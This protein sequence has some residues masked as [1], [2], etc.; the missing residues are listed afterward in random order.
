MAVDMSLPHDRIRAI[1]GFQQVGPREGRQIA[2]P[3]GFTMAPN[4]LLVSSPRGVSA[5][6]GTRPRVMAEDMMAV[7]HKMHDTTI[8]SSKALSKHLSTIAHSIHL[9]ERHTHE[10]EKYARWERSRNTSFFERTMQRMGLGQGGIIRG[11][12]GMGGSAIGGGASMVGRLAMGGGAAMLRGLAGLLGVGAPAVG[13]LARSGLSGVMQ[14]GGTAMTGLRRLFSRGLPAMP[15]GGAST[16]SMLG[17]LLPSGAAGLGSRLAGWGGTA[18]KMGGRMLGWPLA[19]LSAVGIGGY[20][21]YQGYNNA[22]SMLGRKLGPKEVQG[23]VAASLGGALS[24]LGT[25][26]IAKLFGH[27]NTARAIDAAITKSR[28]WLSGFTDHVGDMAKKAFAGT[29][30]AAETAVRAF[31][32]GEALN[33]LK[34]AIAGG[35]ESLTQ[36]IKGFALS[37]FESAKDMLGKLFDP[38]PVDGGASRGGYE[39]RPGDTFAKPV[40]PP[41]A[42]ASGGV[43]SGMGLG[44]GAI[45]EAVRRSSA[46]MAK[47]VSGETIGQPTQLEEAM[48]RGFHSAVAGIGGAGGTAAGALAG[49][50]AP[51]LDAAANGLSGAVAGPPSRDPV[52]KAREKAK[53]SYLDKMK[54]FLEKKMRD[55]GPMGAWLQSQGAAALFKPTPFSSGMPNGWMGEGGSGG[56]GGGGGGYRGSRGGGG[57]GGGGGDGDGDGPR[58]SAT[59][60][61]E[62][63]VS[64]EGVGELPG[65]GAPPIDDNV[66]RFIG[67][68]GARETGFRD[69]EAA[70][71]ANNQPGNNSNVRRAMANGMSQEDAMAKYGDYGYFQT[72]QNDVE[73]AI[74]LG[75]PRDVAQAL[76]NGG[77]R[78][79]YSVEEQTR[80]MD[81]YLQKLSPEGYEAAK[82]GDWDTANNAFKGKWPS[83]PGGASHKSAN[84]ALAD[85]ALSGQTIRGQYDN[86]GSGL[87]AQA[88]AKQLEQAHKRVMEAAEAETD[89]DKQ[90]KLYGQADRIDKL[91]NQAASMDRENNGNRDRPV[92]PGS[93]DGLNGA[94]PHDII[95]GAAAGRINPQSAAVDKAMEMLGLHEQ[96]DRE[97][98]QEYLANGGQGLDPA[99]TPWCA[100]F[101]NSSLSQSGITGSGSAVANSFQEWGHD[102]GSDVSGWKRGDVLVKHRGLG[103]GET[104]GHVGMFTGRTREV[105]GETQVEMISGN[106]GNRV[107]KTWENPDELMAR[108]SKEAVAAEKAAQESG[109]TRSAGTPDGRGNSGGSEGG[110]D[111]GGGDRDPGAPRR[112]T[113]STTA[114]PGTVDPGRG[115]YDPRG[116]GGAAGGQEEDGTGSPPTYTSPQSSDAEPTDVA[117]EVGDAVRGAMDGAGGGGGGSSEPTGASLEEIDGNDDI[118]LINANMID[119]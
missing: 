77:G 84:D 52:A 35:M 40:R 65:G 115:S 87:P 66:N 7:L 116:D 99:D 91:R 104:G 26:Y 89:P 41:T 14:H 32:E 9:V 18:L 118:Y 112:N 107:A 21:A 22:E 71:D 60:D 74:R 47:T 23:K 34:D 109:R 48:R 1:L 10:M 5:V 55:V 82:R 45:L 2:L 76:N 103:P 44:S 111:Q 42:G 33:G 83:L 6:A 38:H 72:N 117:A 56:G 68:I 29:I 11:L 98:I 16:L 110:G 101:V 62:S 86:K 119:A 39:Y 105:D 19:L 36:S 8:K 90:Q 80:A 27:E 25:D 50:Y 93:G 95:A 31:Q 100:D 51:L 24:T 30:G 102:A 78:G 28:D 75:V 113:G 17:D 57:G 3:A 114:I 79:N 70:T 88:T 37:A 92:R 49:G 94:N 63:R 54:S 61:N 106:Q 73:H 85:R 96:G 97:K 59:G 12:L 53:T 15:G 46:R 20:G 58:R 43:M 4:G 64:T 108:R 67:S 81:A 13:A 69:S